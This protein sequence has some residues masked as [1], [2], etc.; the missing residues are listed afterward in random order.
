D[1]CDLRHVI[2][3]P[4]K[5]RLLHEALADSVK[6]LI[7]IVHDARLEIGLERLDL[8][9]REVDGDDDGRDD[10]N[11]LDEGEELGET[12]VGHW[13]PDGKR[14]SSRL[15]RPNNLFD[16]DAISLAWPCGRA[17]TWQRSF[18]VS[19]HCCSTSQ[20]CTSAPRK[21]PRPGSSRSARLITV[22]RT[23]SRP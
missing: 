2:Q 16:G 22:A 12:E 3:N 1:G 10:R 14:A 18:P 5:L 9:A 6:L 19:R 21:R 15:R 4:D 11:R 20:D 13:R 7:E 23:R 8:A 17:Q